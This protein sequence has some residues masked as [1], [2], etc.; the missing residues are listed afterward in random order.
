MDLELIDTSV[1]LYSTTISARGVA[2]PGNGTT[3]VPRT[4]VGLLYIVLHSYK[5]SLGQSVLPN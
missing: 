5:V 4:F 2:T 3:V 1:Q